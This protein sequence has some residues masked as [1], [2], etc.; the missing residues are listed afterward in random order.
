MTEIMV[1]F[2]NIDQAMEAIQDEIAKSHVALVTVQPGNTGK[3]STARLWRAWMATTAQWMAARGA[4]MPLGPLESQ[5]Q[6]GSRPFNQED[7][8]ELFTALHG[9][10]DKHGERLSWSRS[11]RDG[12]RPATKGERVAMLMRHEAWCSERGIALINPRDSEYRR[13]TQEMDNG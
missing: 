12:M 9:Y 8:H 7:A 13:L 4:T 1:T 5:R 2:G 11:G 10:T 6:Y 3:W